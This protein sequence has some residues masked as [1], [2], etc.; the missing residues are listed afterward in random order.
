MTAARFH[1]I[2]L[3]VADL[4]PGSLVRRR[5]GPHARRRAPG[6]ARGGVRTVVLSGADGLR[7]EFVDGPD[8]ALPHT[9]I[10]S[11]PPPCRPSPTWLFKSRIS[12]PR[13]PASPANAPPHGIA[14]RPG[15]TPGMRYAYVADPEGNLLELI[16]VSGE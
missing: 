3:S 4:T 12:T 1:H 10:P 15:V 5:V 6:D 11:P 2:S 8:R 16:E 7:V 9:P 14:A 13:S